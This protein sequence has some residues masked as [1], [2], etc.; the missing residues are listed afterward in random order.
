MPSTYCDSID[1]LALT[2]E[3][4]FRTLFISTDKRSIDLVSEPSFWLIH[5]TNDSNK[6]AN[7]GLVVFLVFSFTRFLS[8]LL[9]Y[10]RLS[11]VCVSC[12]RNQCFWN[13]SMIQSFILFNLMTFKCT[14][15]HSPKSMCLL[16]MINV[17]A[18]IEIFATKLF[19]ARTLC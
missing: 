7:T 12:A 4:W 17:D 9:P 18:L 16:A 3:A 15:S 5:S 19:F 13:M 8:T 10:L 6:V 14:A 11:Y 1:V 2:D